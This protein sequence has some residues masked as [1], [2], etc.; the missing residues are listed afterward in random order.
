M[1]AVLPLLF[2]LAELCVVA[3]ENTNFVR[4]PKQEL[5]VNEAVPRIQVSIERL[6]DTNATVSV[7]YVV[8]AGA[9]AEADKDF[10]ATQGTLSFGPGETNRSISITILDD[11]IPESTK[12][13]EVALTNVVGDSVLT[14]ATA[15]IRLI[16]NDGRANG[17]DPTFR[18][19]YTNVA[20]I[21]DVLLVPDGKIWFGSASTVTPSA[22]YGVIEQNGMP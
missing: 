6:G 16:D 13:I 12:F 17:I 18:F 21:N 3:Q 2:L 5:T 15:S 10:T 22:T 14:N 9:G 1:R 11:D 7:D 20:G 4:F 8:S 19:G